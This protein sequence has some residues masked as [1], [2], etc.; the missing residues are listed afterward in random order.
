MNNLTKQKIAIE[1]IKTLVSRFDN[2]PED[3][4]KNRN[5]PF[6]EAFLRAFENKLDGKV[7]D[8]PFLI[9]LSSW[10][11]GL[12]TTLG[13]QFF[14]KVAHILSGG[15]KKEFTSGRLGNLDITRKQSENASAIITSLSHQGNPSLESENQI[16]LQMD[17]SGLEKAMNLSADVF[18]E[19]DDSVTAIELKSVKPNSGEM[20]GEKHKILEG[21]ARLFHR[22][23]NKKI[24]FFVGFPFDPTA[25]S[26]SP[27][28]YDKNRFLD[29]IINMTKY[30]DADEV[31]LSSE[32]WNKL[33]GEARTMEQ[34][35][36]IINNISAVDFYENFRFILESSNREDTKYREI[37]KK[38]HLYTE[39]EL[40]D[41]VS[42]I[43]RRINNDKKLK[44]LYAKS[45]MN[46][47][48]EY[49]FERFYQLKNLI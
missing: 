39:I 31:L 19:D 21:K 9:T 8:T 42:V 13:Q 22:Y 34:I 15:D 23:P 20:K 30:F 17:K 47:K 45:P 18:F 44:R 38:W 46:S 41:S 12:N 49:D 2:F 27:T 36:E 3:S 37:L 40:L 24:E 29:S 1:V 14:E 33:S 26:S 5:A 7:S 28:S 43:T 10:L 6:H 16:L 32:L 35:L 4:L 48:G 11:H 25:P